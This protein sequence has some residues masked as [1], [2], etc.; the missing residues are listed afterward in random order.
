MNHK[1]PFMF[2]LLG[3]SQK[4]LYVFGDL[5]CLTDDVFCAWQGGIFLPLLPWLHCIRSWNRTATNEKKM[6]HCFVHCNS[7]R[8]RFI[9][10]ILTDKH[11]F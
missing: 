4:L 10:F 5:L 9:Y 1:L 2:G 3:S 11:R 8:Q 7:Q 6:T